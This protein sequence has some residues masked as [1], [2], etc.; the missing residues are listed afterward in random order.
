M[1]VTAAAIADPTDNG[2][3]T[4]DGAGSLFGVLHGDG[5]P[6]VYLLE[7]ETEHRNFYL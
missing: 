6:F 2:V 3:S 7:N 1:T 5:Q 4:D